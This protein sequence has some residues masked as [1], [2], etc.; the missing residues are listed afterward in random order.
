M[1]RL[2]H[3]AAKNGHIDIVKIL[4]A[5]DGININVKDKD[6][7]TPFDLAKTEEIK[8]LL[9]KAAEKTDDS[10]ASK[11]N[12]GDQKEDIEQEGN[13]QSVIQVEEKLQEIIAEEVSGVQIEDA[14]NGHSI[15]IALT[16]NGVNPRSESSTN[17]E[18][19]SSFFSSLFGILIKPFS[20]IG[21]FFGGFFFMVVWI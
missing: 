5:V 19:P 18:Q 12:E 20:L 9:K 3:Y 1:N 7:K 2:L 6:E 10:I 14:D 17:E 15:D 21:S 16:K 8:A 4:L 13:A 11:D